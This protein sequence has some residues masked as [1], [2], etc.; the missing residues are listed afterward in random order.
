MIL[1][2]TLF[3]KVSVNICKSSEFLTQSCVR[4]YSFIN[5]ELKR[6]LN[7]YLNH[8]EWYI[9]LIF[10]VWS[11]DNEL[12]F[13][14]CYVSLA[15]CFY[16]ES[17]YSLSLIYTDEQFSWRCF[18]NKITLNDLNSCLHC[19]D[20]KKINL[21]LLAQFFIIHSNTFGISS[22]KNWFHFSIETISNPNDSY[23]N[24]VD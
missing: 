20:S 9:Y 1:I 6:Y 13:F 2:R 24:F 14:F 19:S 16:L 7:V 4:A 18:F 17:F 12:L 8:Y 21:R 5:N 11:Y 22:F 15:S 23:E 10:S 3:I